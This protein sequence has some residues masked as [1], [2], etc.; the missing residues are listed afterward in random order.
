MGNKD[1]EEF[2]GRHSECHDKTQHGARIIGKIQ[3]LRDWSK[4]ILESGPEQ[5]GGGSSVFEPLAR[6]GS[7]DC[8]RP[9]G[10]GSFYF[11][12]EWAHC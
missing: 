9:I 8:Q 3:P 11:K 7:F 5:K 6:G 2:F 12:Q 4:S 10:G 1:H